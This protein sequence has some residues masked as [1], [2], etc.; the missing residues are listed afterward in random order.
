MSGSVSIVDYGSGNLFSVV[1]AFEHVGA[2][3]RLAQ[4]A[5]AIEAAERLVLPGV[6]AFADGMAGLSERGLVEPIRRFAASGRPLLGICLGMQMLAT[7][8]EEFGEHAG[9]GIIPG[10][11]VPIPAQDVD[12]RSQKIPHIGWADLQPWQARGWADSPLQDLIQGDAVY[13]VHSF[14]FVPDDAQDGLAVCGYGGHRIT[15]AVRSG[16]T[17]GCQF[18]PEKSGEVGLR[19]LR[20]FLQAQTQVQSVC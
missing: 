20:R 19:V 13:L 12:G 16:G 5:A 9:L 1:R 2:E 11:V 8:S 7:S 10:R 6:G 14:H 18:H 15:A 3:A 4:D 17:V